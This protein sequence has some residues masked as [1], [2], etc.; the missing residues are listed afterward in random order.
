MSNISGK[1]YEELLTLLPFSGIS[2]GNDLY[3]AVVLYFE[4]ENLNLKKIISVTTDGVPAM[5]GA[6]QGF[7]QRLRNDPKCNSD[8][9]SYHCIIHQ[10]VLCCELD[11]C[12]EKIMKTV[13]SIVNFIRAKSSLQHRL[14]KALGKMILS[15]TIYYFIIM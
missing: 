2:N 9:L 4:T 3:N 11:P 13:M 10:S 12:L 1:F 8:L 6:H 7:V 5:I 15:L 14:F